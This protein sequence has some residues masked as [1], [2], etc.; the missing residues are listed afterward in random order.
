AV[1]SAAI[2]G[3]CNDGFFPERGKD[4][5]LVY[6]R[7][8]LRG[9]VDALRDEGV[10][11]RNRLRRRRVLPGLLRNG[12]LV[13]PNQ[14]LAVRAIEN[15][16]PARFVWFACSLPESSVDHDIEQNDRA[17]PVVIPQVMV[18]LLEVP[19]VFSGPGIDG[20]HRRREQVVAFAYPAVKIRSGIACGEV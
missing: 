5:P 20:D 14:R 18:D 19:F 8:V 16:N 13:D 3:L 15:I 7:Q 6:E 17:W 12:L 4:P 10:A 2:P 11:A 9:N 1:G